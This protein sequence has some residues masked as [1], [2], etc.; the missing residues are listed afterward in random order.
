[1]DYFK[2]PECLE[3]VALKIAT[4][5]GKHVIIFGAMVGFIA[6]AGVI[7]GPLPVVWPIIVIACVGFALGVSLTYGLNKIAKKIENIISSK[8][9]KKALFKYCK[10]HLKIDDLET[11]SLQTLQKHFKIKFDN[12]EISKKK[13]K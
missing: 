10:K 9:F 11:C 3:A 7:A 8:Y 4:R 6:L 5:I 12:H 2:Q 13:S 1:M